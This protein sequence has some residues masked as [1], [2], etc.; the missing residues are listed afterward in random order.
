M[1]EFGK[2]F[3]PASNA[4]VHGIE[5]DGDGN[6]WMRAV[7]EEQAGKKRKNGK[8]K[9]PSS[10]PPVNKQRT[11]VQAHPAFYQLEHG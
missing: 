6:Y 9:P 7:I 5:V 8:G 2:R 1:E 4:R 3:P 11:E 10:A